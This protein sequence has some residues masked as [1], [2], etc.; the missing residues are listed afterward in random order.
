[1]RAICLLVIA[2]C[3]AGCGGSDAKPTTASIN[4]PASGTAAGTDTA[5][6]DKSEQAKTGE[7][8]RQLLILAAKLAKQ[9]MVGKAVEQLS[10]AISINPENA[11][12][13]I[14]RAEVYSL[15]REDANALADYS[16][17][18][19]VRPKDAS[20]YNRRGFFL[21]SRSE[22]TRALKDFSQAIKLSPKSAHAYNN[23]GLVYLSISQPGK[24]IADFR[25]AVKLDPKYADGWNNLGFA[26]Y[27]KEEFAD[28]VTELTKALKCKPDYVNALNNRALAYYHLGKFDAAVK[29]F[30]V[31]IK[32][33]PYEVKLYQGRKAVYQ[34]LNQFEK[35]QADASKL[36]WLVGLAAMTKELERDPRN[37]SHY[38]KRGNY[39]TDGGEYAAAIRDFSLAAKLRTSIAEP[40]LRRATA[41]LAN[42]DTDDAMT[43]VATAMELFRSA[44][45]RLEGKEVEQVMADTAAVTDAGDIKQA[46]SIR[47]DIYMQ[48]KKYDLAVQ[49]Y[50]RAERFDSVVAEAYLRRAVAFDKAGRKAEA[51]ADR[52]QAAKIDPTRRL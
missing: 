26:H 50:E 1:M 52:G 9:G 44:A 29:D 27:R 25:Q 28:A 11:E 14:A 5:G 21:L 45:A 43:D 32:A 40:L 20:I 19:R 13:Y 30:S 42:G 38:I 12:L 8:S 17:A 23:R 18:L 10:H 41:R 37:Y 2:G 51:A 16:V 4:N 33:S 7:E 35:A 24:A 22:H 31:A 34:K 46:Y 36:D 39:L 47:A 48:Q 3:L 49:D 15:M 6:A